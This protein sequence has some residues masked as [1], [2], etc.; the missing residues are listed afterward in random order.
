MVSL[1]RKPTTPVPVP[2]SAFKPA[3]IQAFIEDLFLNDLHAKRVRSLADAPLG[4]LQAGALGIHAIGRGL[5]AARGLLTKHA[6]KQVDRLIGNSGVSVWELF[7]QWVPFVIGQRKELQVNLD[8]TEFDKDGHSMLMASLQTSHGRSTPLMWKSFETQTFKGQRNDYEDELLVRLREVIPADV[9]V[10]IVADRGF[11]DTKL[12]EFLASLGFG[13]VI[14]F[15]SVI[16][17]TAARGETRKAKEWLG[18]GGQMRVLRNAQV[19]GQ[20]VAVP[21]VV[22]VHEKDMKDAWCIVSSDPKLAGRDV[23]AIYGRRFSIEEMFRDQKDL[24]FGMGLSWRIVG[25]VGRRDRLMLIAALAQALLTLL[26]A[27]GEELGMDR[28]LKTN[29]SKTRTISLFRQ[30]LMWYE[31]IPNMPGERPGTLMNR[32]GEML[33]QQTIF[34]KALGIL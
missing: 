6:V 8:Q 17:V 13:Y 20:N 29:T 5:A 21:T 12:Y 27:A 9:A 11:A 10:T 24:R 30:G 26:G 18:A 25:D 31:L 3:D 4:A 19:T 14:R 28:Y 16:F 2:P 22:C 23:K 32:F 1:M 34:A 7:A 33:G 15:R